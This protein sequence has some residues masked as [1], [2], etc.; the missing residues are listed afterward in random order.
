MIIDF[1]VRPP[2]KSFLNLT[3]HRGTPVAGGRVGW[4]TPRPPSSRQKSFELFLSE[5][6][7]A[8][9]AHAVIWG[10]V[11]ANANNSTA[12]ED[13]VELVT[14]YP[15]LFAGLGGMRTPTGG[16][17]SQAVDEVERIISKLGLKG[18]TLEP[19]MGMTMTRGAD[20]PRLY[21]VYE[22]CERLGGIL[23]F[24][25]SVRAGQDMS[26]SSP[27]AVDRVAGDFPKLKIV[28]SHLFWPRIDEACGL[29]FRRTNVYLLA[30]QYGMTMPGHMLLI[31][32]ANTY[33]ENRVLFGSSYPSW[34]GLKEMSA[35]YMRLP[36]RPDVREKVMYKNAAALL[37]L[38]Q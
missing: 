33:L 19:G 17:I 23:A 31:E 18:I 3:Q 28:V 2:F 30:D 24:T 11:V 8:D 20:D 27:V 25:L 34:L 32:A 7:E 16:E 22:R 35:G 26:F 15:T 37:G 13:I 5:M 12:N 29:A 4:N 21:P 9:V 14:K 6:K 38:G 10:R 1:R 36:Y